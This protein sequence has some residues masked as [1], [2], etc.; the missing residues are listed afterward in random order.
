MQIKTT[1]KY[2]LKPIG[3]AIIKKLKK[4]EFLLWY[5]GLRIRLQQLWLLQRHGFDPTQEQWLKY[6]LLWQL[7]HRLQLQLQFNPG[8]VYMP[9]VRL[10]KKKCCRVNGAD[11]FA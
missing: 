1:T 8:T 7:W 4:Q 11:G 6:P 2:Y 10:L 5:N 9:Q 3:M